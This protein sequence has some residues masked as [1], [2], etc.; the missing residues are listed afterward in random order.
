MKNNEGNSLEDEFSADFQASTNDYG[1]AFFA[2]S[3]TGPVAGFDN[4]SYRLN[5][6]ATVYTQMVTIV[7]TN[8]VGTVKSGFAAS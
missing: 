5:A 2:T 1:L 4:V 7:S 8:I 6:W 3:I